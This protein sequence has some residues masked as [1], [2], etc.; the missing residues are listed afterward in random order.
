[1]KSQR[2]TY[3]PLTKSHWKSLDVPR[4]Q[5]VVQQVATALGGEAA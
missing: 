2:F 4:R 1:M 5:E 3:K